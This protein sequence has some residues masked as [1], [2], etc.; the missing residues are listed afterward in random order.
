VDTTRRVTA[1]IGSYFE[2]VGR[3]VLDFQKLYSSSIIDLE[4]GNSMLS[5]LLVHRRAQSEEVEIL[6]TDLAARRKQQPAAREAGDGQGGAADGR[7]P[8][9]GTD[10]T[11]GS[12]RRRPAGMREVS[13]LSCFFFPLEKP[14]ES[15]GRF[16]EGRGPWASGNK[17]G[18]IPIKTKRTAKLF[19]SQN[20]TH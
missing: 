14:T 6:G 17:T 18:P 16:R 15:L 4:N 12:L 5:W 13:Q 20:K 1:H 9:K 8:E 10:V 11:R 19:F 7:M 3:W 2:S